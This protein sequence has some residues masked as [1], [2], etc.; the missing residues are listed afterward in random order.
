MK[1]VKLANPNSMFWD[2]ELEFGVSGDEVKA[3]PA[4]VPAGSLTA[5]WIA[6]GGLLDAEAPIMPTEEPEVAT[7]G[8]VAE[9]VEIEADLTPPP[10][11]KKEKPAE[12]VDVKAPVKK[13]RKPRS[14]KQ[15]K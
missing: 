4:D 6:A 13:T 14:K 11:E 5:K 10:A 8:A 9:E 2:R 1:K 7:E 12:E 3:L 15:A